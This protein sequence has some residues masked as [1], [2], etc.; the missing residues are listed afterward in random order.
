MVMMKRRIFKDDKLEKH[1]RDKGYVIIDIMTEQEADMLLAGYNAMDAEVDERH[2][3]YSTYWSENYDYR[4]AVD[5]LVRNFINEK[6]K[7]HVNQFRSIVGIFLSKRV[8]DNSDCNPHQDWCY[9][10]ESEFISL[11][12]WCPLT[13]ITENSGTL[14]VLEGSHRLNDLVRGRSFHHYIAKVR[15]VIAKRFLK[16]LLIK[17]GQAIIMNARLIHGSQNNTSS[18]ERVAA[19]V[20]AIPVEAKS[21]HYVADPVEAEVV[22]MIDAEDDFHVK[23]TCFDMV[24]TT[25]KS[26]K[27]FKNPEKYLSLVQLYLLRL[28]LVPKV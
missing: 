6:L 19:S 9:V 18:M 4:K 2:K 20:A 23:H 13:E 10:D 3:F 28:G 14:A 24:D 11:T 22:H 1:F 21:I 5:R 7:P 16:P 8:G 17:K 12:V 25:E 26:I 15:P 27:K